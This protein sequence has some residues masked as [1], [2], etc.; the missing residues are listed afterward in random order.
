[1]KAELKDVPFL[2][3]MCNFFFPSLNP[4]SP[5]RLSKTGHITKGLPSTCGRLVNINVGQVVERWNHLCTKIGSSGVKVLNQSAA[6]PQPSLINRSSSRRG[7]V[8]I[9]HMMAVSN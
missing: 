1:M 4:F 6:T 3:H 7:G 5:L 8:T 2:R 9:L